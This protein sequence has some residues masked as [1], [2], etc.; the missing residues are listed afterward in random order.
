MR[1][2]MK[3]GKTKIQWI[4]GAA[5]AG[6]FCFLL[7][8]V[9]SGKEGCLDDPIRH[10][11]YGLRSDALTPLAIGIT[12]LSNTKFI[13]ALC[14][15]LLILPQT[16]N[17]YGIP[18]SMGAIFVTILNKTIKHIIQRLRPEDIEHLV[19][20]G[21]YSFPSG[22]SITSMFVYGMLLYLIWIH[23]K[24]RRLRNILSVLVMIP[25]VLV[26][27]SRI[28]LGVHYPTDVLAGWCLGFA[29]LMAAIG[30]V[31]RV[32]AGREKKSLQKSLQKTLQKNNRKEGNK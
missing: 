19:Q 30:V 1:H 5:A 7:L 20:E 29:V 23:V 17:I 6:G 13:I 24:D 11:F 15:I 4:A 3:T 16:R 14:L 8:L 25:L 28:Y 32:T 2:S 31:Q 18:V 9:L 26:G 22:H 27:P 21:G 12:D 10:F